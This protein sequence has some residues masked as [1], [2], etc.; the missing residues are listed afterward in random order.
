MEKCAVT[1]GAGF[2]GSHLVDKLLEL[3]CEVTVVDNLFTGSLE[4]IKHN[5]NK[6]AFKFK[7]ISVLYND[8]E[9]IFR[10]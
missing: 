4:N 5:L 1:G 9:K 6:R 8:L 10:M 7:R 3:G 2:I